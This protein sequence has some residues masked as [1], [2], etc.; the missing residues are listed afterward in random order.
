LA[1]VLRTAGDISVTTAMITDIRGEASFVP[2][3]FAA[4]KLTGVRETWSVVAA[5]ATGTINIDCATSTALLY[6]TNASANFTLNLRASGAAALTTLVA[7]GEA[8]TV[9][10]AATQGAT[11]YVL[12]AVQID[13]AAQTVRWQDAAVPTGTAS[14]ID[15]YSITAIRTGAGTWT[16]LGNKA[17]FA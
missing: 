4:A 12:S 8:I 15:I 5:A 17:A 3:T 6:T 14:G 7:I 2:S 16:V 1:R 11:P 13:G 9:V 10:F